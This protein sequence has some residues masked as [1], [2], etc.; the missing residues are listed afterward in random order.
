MWQVAFKEALVL[1]FWYLIIKWAYSNGSEVAKSFIFEDFIVE[2]I[3]KIKSYS[4]VIGI[5]AVAAGCLF[6]LRLWSIGKVIEYN[7]I[8]CYK[9]FFVLSV[10]SSIGVLFTFQ[11]SKETQKRRNRKAVT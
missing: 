4:V 10:P 7:T 2:D 9:I 1:F 3:D 11:K 8:F 6:F 5:S